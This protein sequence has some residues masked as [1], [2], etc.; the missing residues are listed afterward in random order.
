[1]DDSQAPGQDDEHDDDA[2]IQHPESNDPSRQV[3]GVDEVQTIGMYANHY[4]LY[5]Y[6]YIFMHSQYVVNIYFRLILTT[7]YLLNLPM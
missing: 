2:D 6:T 7:H 3:I 1:M 4:C 5:V